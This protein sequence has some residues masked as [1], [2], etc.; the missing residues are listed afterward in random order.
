MLSNMQS[1][2]VWTCGR[3]S[4]ATCADCDTQQ[5]CRRRDL[6]YDARISRSYLSP[7]EKGSVYVSIKVIGKLAE[8]LAVEPEEF[9][10]RPNKRRDR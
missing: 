10:K 9:L 3:Y 2:F 4:P 5:A 7:L 6:A 8:T 1:F